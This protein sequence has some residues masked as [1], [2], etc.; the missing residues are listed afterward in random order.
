M[1]IYC[2]LP[3]WQDT[4]GIPTKVAVCGPKDRG[5]L[6]EEVVFMPGEL[7]MHLDTAPANRQ[8]AILI[9]TMF[10]ILSFSV[11]WYCQYQLH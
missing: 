9:S 4:L 5:I 10:D 3:I 8:K 7:F 1:D 11:I 2:L 6:A